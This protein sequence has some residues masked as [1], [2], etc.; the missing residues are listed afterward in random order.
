[1]KALHTRLPRI[2][3]LIGI[4]LTAALL[5][6]GCSSSAA[7]SDAEQ[8]ALPAA[9][10]TTVYP[11]TLESPY[12]KTVLDKR[13]ERIAAVVPTAVDTEMLLALGIRPVL[14][15]SMINESASTS[16]LKPYD[17]A[18]LDTYEF[19]VGANLPIEAIA[20]SEPDLIVAV[21]WGDG[22]AGMSMG[23]YYDRLSSI[24]PVLTNAD[25]TSQMLVP[26]QDSIRLLGTAVDLSMAADKV[27]AEHDDY[28]GMLRSENPKLAGRTATW[29]VWYGSD[30]GLV[31]FSQP[32]SAPETFLRELG[33]AANPRASTFSATNTVSP[34]LL[35]TIDAD[36][37]LLGR[38]AAADEDD[39]DSLTSGPLF[40]NLGAVSSGHWVGV[41]P[42]TA[43]GGDI[44]W[45][46]TSGGPIGTTWAAEQII[47]LVD[48]KL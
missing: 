14:S 23:D 16:Y 12:G 44:L 9:E 15:S 47:P 20:A 24:A 26:W 17:A 2:A 21:G 31:Y 8:S 32:G 36:F 37:L 3:G 7:T 25:T 27:I 45:A 11:L 28:F 46:I 1:M 48:A 22:L 35:D 18:S 43:D 40:Q 38:S 33:F 4:V 10:G 41:P 42:H 29:A 30:Y 34:E 39:F 19:V 5:A 13:P 6:T